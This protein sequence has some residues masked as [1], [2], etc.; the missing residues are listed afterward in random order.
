VRVVFGVVVDFSSE[1]LLLLAGW[2]TSVGYIALHSSVRLAIVRYSLQ[3][4]GTSGSGSSETRSVV[5][6]HTPHMGLLLTV[7]R[8]ASSRRP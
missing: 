2:D 3:E 5:V 6:A 1:L 4:G 7:P 8:R